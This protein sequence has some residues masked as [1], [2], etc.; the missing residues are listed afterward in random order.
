[1]LVMEPLRTAQSTPFPGALPEGGCNMA[2]ENVTIP[3][4]RTHNCATCSEAC[5]DDGQGIVGK[6]EKGL[7]NMSKISTEDMLK[8]LNDLSES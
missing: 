2:D 3:E 7:E 6:F 1:M 8:M 5:S 4:D